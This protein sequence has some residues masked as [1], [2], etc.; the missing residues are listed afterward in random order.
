MFFPIIL[1]FVFLNVYNVTEH[2]RVRKVKT[3]QE[4][5]NSYETFVNY[6]QSKE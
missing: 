6:L 2:I 5:D 3:S 4:V 1:F